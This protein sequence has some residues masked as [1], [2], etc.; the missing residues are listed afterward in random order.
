M[1]T[2]G[3][4]CTTTVFSALAWKG[5]LDSIFLPFL[6]SRL[7]SPDCL[8]MQR[9]CVE[10]HLQGEDRCQEAKDC[11]GNGRL[12][13]FSRYHLAGEEEV[14]IANTMDILVAVD[15]AV[16]NVQ[17]GEESPESCQCTL[18]HVRILQ[19][20]DLA[21]S[22]HDHC[23]DTC[24][25]GHDDRDQERHQHDDLHENYDGPETQ[26]SVV[27]V[28]AAIAAFGAQERQAPPQRLLTLGLCFLR[29]WLRTAKPAI[30]PKAI[31]ERQCTERKNEREID[32]PDCH[33]KVRDCVEDVRTFLL[34]D[35]ENGVEVRAEF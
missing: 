33:P 11:G 19:H 29:N 12:G 31:V 6:G 24:K 34:E 3:R 27:E 22:C 14:F 4:L 15:G 21:A 35:R 10:Q 25:D 7:S 13:E 2:E 30:C 1:A 16:A 5:L 26:F 17:L 18:T 23:L 20:I 9:C 8:L 28:A 32:D